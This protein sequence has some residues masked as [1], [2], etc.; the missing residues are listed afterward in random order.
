MAEVPT[1]SEGEQALLDLINQARQN[2]L[3][4]ATSLGMDPD[5]ALLDLPELEDLLTNGLPPLVFNQTLYKVAGTHN[6]DMLDNDYYAHDSLDGCTYEGRIRKSGYFASA[7]GESLGMLAFR[8]FIDPADAAQALFTNMFFD[9]LNPLRTEKRN[10]LDPQLRE[11]GVSLSAGSFILDDEAWNVY[12]MTADFGTQVDVYAIEVALLRLINEGRADPRQAIEQAGVGET[13]AIEALGELSW[14]LDASL[15]PLARN[16]KLAKAA[17]GHTQDMIERIYFDTLSPEGAGP[18]DRAALVGYKGYYV[19]E[20]LWAGNLAI[21]DPE[22]NGVEA[23]VE[24]A[25]H[26]Y[27][28]MVRIELDPF[29]GVMINLFNPELTEAGAGFGQ[30]DLDKGMGDIQSISVVAVDFADPVLSRDFILGNVYQDLDGDLAF[31]PMEGISGLTVAISLLGK[32]REF[33]YVTE[34]GPFGSYQI[35][36]AGILAEL[37]VLKKGGGILGRRIL[38]NQSKNSLVDLWVEDY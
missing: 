7:A 30:V 18:A 20:S 6:Q 22:L 5:Q 38:I 21:V 23:I 4:M 26:I 31:S 13:A 9:E 37:V 36:S 32:R 3:A 24:A 1:L 12:V 15:T 25:K 11:V 2:P 34:T 10:I 17:Q 8:N 27:E 29:S 33:V 35:K 14:V 28:E 16:E 19:G